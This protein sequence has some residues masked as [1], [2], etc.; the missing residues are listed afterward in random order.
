MNNCTIEVHIRDALIATI[1]KKAEQSQLCLWQLHGHCS[2][3]QRKLSN[4]NGTTYEMILTIIQLLE[5][6]RK[7][8]T[9]L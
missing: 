2:E 6:S 5:K 7:E 8:D 1:N 4:S 3:F 9:P